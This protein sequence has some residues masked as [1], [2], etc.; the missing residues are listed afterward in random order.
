ME[1]KD[2]YR[3]LGVTRDATPEQI[4]RAYRKLAHKYHPDV[5]KEAQAERRFKEINEAHEALKDPEKR[6][7]YDALGRSWR[8]GQPFHPP[9]GARPRGRETAF[10]T[11][12]IEQFSDF[13]SSLFG[14]GGFR[15]DAPPNAEA[16]ARAEQ[17]PTMP[18]ELTLEEAF[19]GA[20]RQLRIESGD[21]SGGRTLKIRIPAGVTDGQQIR[22]AGQGATVRGVATDL[23][24][25][26]HLAPHPLYRVDGKHLT[27]TLPIAPWEAALGAT[28][29]VPTLG[30]AISL[31][32]PPQSQSGQKLRLR[33]RGLTGNPPGD[34]LVQLEI[35][36]PPVK[37]DA[38]RAVF[39][40]LAEQFSAFQPRATLAQE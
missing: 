5:S 31:R 2:Y 24:V 35:V 26:V 11:E 23:F 17:P 1:Y 38:Q 34:T 6:A 21:G 16:T 29:T 12:D 33:G 4:K 40:R 8:P 19:Q 27:L 39:E 14:R 37:T 13:F 20:V 15:R 36:N 3:I 18:I 9:P 30:G 7:A 32:I 22:L 25:E 28:V 10:A